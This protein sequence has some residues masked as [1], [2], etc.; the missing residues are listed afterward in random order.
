V[1]RGAHPID[2][3]EQVK[4][5][6]WDEEQG[7]SRHGTPVEGGQEDHIQLMFISSRKLGTWQP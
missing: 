4:P 5:G 2:A 3:A 7:F 6:I 1:I